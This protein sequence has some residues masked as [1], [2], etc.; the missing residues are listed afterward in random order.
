MANRITT[1]FDLDS[2][3]FDSGLKNLRTKISET[4]GAFGKMKV[5]ASGVMDTIKANAGAAALGIAGLAVAVGAKAVMAFEDGALAAGRFSD[6][7]GLA[8]EDA[9]RWREVADDMGVGADTMAGN[10]IK[11]EKA[12]GSGKPAVKALGIE[13]KKTADG[14][15]DMSATMLDVI[16]RLGQIQ[17][18]TKKAQLAAELFGRSWADSAEI[19]TGS[20]A[21]IEARLESVSNAQV[22]DEDEV[23]KAREFRDALENLKDKGQA[24]ANELGSALVPALTDLSNAISDIATASEKLKV[25]TWLKWGQKL[26]PLH[27]LHVAFGHINDDLQEMGV[28]SEAAP[29]L[30]PTFDQVASSADDAKGA[31][32]HAKSE[33]AALNDATDKGNSAFQVYAGNVKGAAEATDRKAKADEKAKADA[34]KY[35]A[36]IDAVSDAMEKQRSAALE[37][38]GG[39]IGVREAQREAKKAAEDLND[40]LADQSESLADAGAAIDDAAQSQ[41]DAA[42][43]AAEYRAQQ[44]EANG[45]T[46]DANTKAQLFKEELQKLA[47]GLNGPLAA[48]IQNYIDQLGAIPKTV[49]TTIVLNKPGRVGDI[50]PFQVTNAPRAAGGP[51]Y[52]GL[53]RVLERGPE[54]LQQGGQTFL[55]SNGGGQVVPM[56][57]GVSGGGSPGGQINITVHAGLGADGRS[58]GREII[59]AIKREERFSGAGWRT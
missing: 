3:G 24:L 7:S 30:G 45:E 38:V 42:S 32:A 54:L 22:F 52:P 58:I 43:A 14:Q 29:D 8:T 16:Q 21:D 25:P 40:T 26:S 17:D 15:A 31:L 33:A 27:G 20:A 46:V 39:D 35:R 5:G 9:S 36:S 19:I 1:L 48:A 28:I 12:I 49:A 41:L 57:A 2:K 4:D 23:K 56:S 51:T 6:A 10:F 47:D 53:H 59:T 18:P 11:L 37:L 44:M 13:V 34:D 55:M 50:N